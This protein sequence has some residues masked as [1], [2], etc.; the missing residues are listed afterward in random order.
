MNSA[1]RN[2][3]VWA[4]GGTAMLFL[5]STLDGGMLTASHT[6]GEKGA[7]WIPEQVWILWSREN[8][9]LVPGIEPWLFSP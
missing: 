8:P 3:D 7:G 1:L 2:E 4:S 5:T 9:L 6:F